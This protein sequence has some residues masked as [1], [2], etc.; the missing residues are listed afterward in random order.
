L[1]GNYV[2]MFECVFDFCDRELSVVSSFFIDGMCV[3]P[4]APATSTTGGATFQPLVMMLLM[5]GWY[6]VIFQRFSVANILI[7]VK[8]LQCLYTRTNVVTTPTYG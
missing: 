2:N 1:R 8:M 7:V 4:L 5:S 3:V 6:F